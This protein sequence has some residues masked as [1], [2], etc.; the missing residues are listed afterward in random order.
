MCNNRRF[1]NYVNFFNKANNK[2]KK[3][4]L[5]VVLYIKTRKDK[6][7][8]V[9]QD[10]DYVLYKAIAKH[11]KSGLE[12]PLNKLNLKVS[13]QFLKFEKQKKLFLASDSFENLGV[14]SKGFKKTQKDLI[15][16]L[17]V[18]DKLEKIVNRND[19]RIDYISERLSQMGIY[20]DSVD[21]KTLNSAI[22]VES[23]NINAENLNLNS[24][25][26]I[27]LKYFC[28]EVLA[29]KDGALDFDL[30]ENR[31]VFVDASSEFLH[32]VI[33]TFPYSVATIPDE[34]LLLSNLKNRVL[35]ECILFVAS[36]IKT[37][38]IAESNKE[39]GGLIENCVAISDIQ[40]YAKELKNYF[41]VI[42]KQC[43][44][45]QA[46]Q[47][48]E[49]INATLRCNEASEFLPRSK[50]VAV[51][52]NGIAGDVEKTEE[53]E[54]E[55]IRIEQEKEAQKNISKEELLDL[56][57]SDDE[58]DFDLGETI[59]EEQTT[60]EEVKQVE[61]FESESK[62]QEEVDELVNE[63]ELLLKKDET[64]E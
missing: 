48:E 64:E 43:L 33:F 37:Q 51:L 12:K 28:G 44:K 20:N 58:E 26:G 11:I 7:M 5:I 47:I 9:I 49:E 27:T 52:A 45:E 2:E 24:N 32:E 63:L 10:S 8:S 46:P 34:Y 55:E 62:A 25:G 4:V 42:V 60:G 54:S 35:K 36:K 14:S 38:T 29:F 15:L 40:H 56:L 39:L 53:Q 18:Q 41:N 13:D 6:R 19:Q 61:E 23:K 17:A 59:Q 3:K 22:S 50:R 30:D 57:L 31:D 16:T 21:K 1:I